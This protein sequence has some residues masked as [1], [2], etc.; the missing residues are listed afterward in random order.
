MFILKFIRIKVYINQLV[1]T[2]NLSYRII[3]E[4]IRKKL[5][6][7][8]HSHV[9]CQESKSTKIYQKIFQITAPETKEPFLHFCSL[10]ADALVTVFSDA[11]MRGT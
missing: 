5:Y 8:G 7:I 2:R 6:L 1:K 4:F 10:D 3:L 9:N 11:E